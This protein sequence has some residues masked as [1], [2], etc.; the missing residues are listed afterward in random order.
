MLL[1]C[2]STARCARKEK[3]APDARTPRPTI[4]VSWPMV[5]NTT[6]ILVPI[7]IES[8]ANARSREDAGAAGLNTSRIIP[9]FLLQAIRAKKAI[10]FKFQ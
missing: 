1:V 2:A 4:T 6:G 7:P 5:E 8:V 10:C 9:S 3:N